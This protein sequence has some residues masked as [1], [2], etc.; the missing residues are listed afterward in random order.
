MTVWLTY[1]NISVSGTCSQ[2]MPYKWIYKAF[3][4]KEIGSTCDDVKSQY[5]CFLFWNNSGN[6]V[7]N[8]RCKLT[9]KCDISTSDFVDIYHFLL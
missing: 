9:V 5:S 4:Y 3:V 8:V 7:F 2:D 1:R 6:F